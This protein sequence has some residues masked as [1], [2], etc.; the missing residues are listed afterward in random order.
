M[1][2][3]HSLAI[4]EYSKLYLIK[5]MRITDL[6]LFQTFKEYNL[7]SDTNLAHN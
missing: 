4:Y 7:I 3:V 6:H 1:R 2:S 5:L